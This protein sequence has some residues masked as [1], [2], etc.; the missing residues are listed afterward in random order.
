MFFRFYDRPG[1]HL[2]LEEQAVLKKELF[3]IAQTSFDPVP[4]YQCLSS[5]SDALEDKLIVVAYTDGP[6]SSRAVAFTSAIYLDVPDVPHAVLHTGLTIAMPRVQRTGILMQLFVKLFLHEMP[7]HP[8][9]MWVTTLAAVLS[10]LVQTG[11][12]LSKP[13]PW[14]ATP[15][16][17]PQPQREH[18][19]I[20]RAID[21]RYRGKMLIAPD[22]VW[23]AEHFVFRGSV[24]WEAGEGF[25]KDGDDARFWHRD[26]G[27]NDFF[28]GLMRPGKGDEV[29]LIGFIDED[30]MWEVIER[31]QQQKSRL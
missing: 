24:D 18:L 8:G 28:R 13:Y 25:K 27:A 31:W 7:L 21:E 6:E 29:L 22:A 16:R 20:A 11:T 1:H 3:A 26:G 9:G 15:T 4:D 12:M 5:R 19:A 10:S 2:P 17:Q 23:D 30:R 14:V